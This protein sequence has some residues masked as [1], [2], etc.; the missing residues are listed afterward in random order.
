MIESRLRGV[1]LKIGAMQGP[2]KDYSTEVGS[3]SATGI[4]GGSQQLKGI[5]SRKMAQRKKIKHFLT[6][7]CGLNLS[8]VT[9]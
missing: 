6:P 3:V 1:G 8:Q 4:S 9:R 7:C 2:D 5:S